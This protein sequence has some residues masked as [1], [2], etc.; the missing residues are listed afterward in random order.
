MAKA[1]KR[2]DLDGHY[3]IKFNGMTGWI[4]INEFGE[5]ITSIIGM[6]DDDSF[7][8][9]VKGWTLYGDKVQ[10]ARIGGYIGYKW[11]FAGYGFRNGYGFNEYVVKDVNMMQKM[12]NLNMNVEGLYE[13]IAG[14][15]ASLDAITACI[16]DG[17]L[18]T[19]NS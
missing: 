12:D 1:M 16:A 3:L 17:K 7:D 5:D 9:S 10:V 2:Y 15:Q 8:V 11:D 4:M 14:L 19:H 13:V 6:C 18:N